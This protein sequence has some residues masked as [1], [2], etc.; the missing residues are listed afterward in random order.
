MIRNRGILFFSLAL[1]ALAFADCSRPE[2]GNGIG[3][4]IRPPSSFQG[5]DSLSVLIFTGPSAWEAEVDSLAELLSAHQLSYRE[6]SSDELN[7]MSLQELSSFNLLIVPGG[8]APTM[9]GSLTAAT[10]QRLRD[11]VQLRGLNYLGFCAGAWLAVAPAPSQPGADVV[12]G[13]GIVPGPIQQ[14]TPMY[15]QRKQFSINRARF[16]DGSRRDLLW[17]GG[18][19]T[20]NLQG[21]VVVEYEDGHPAVSQI[22]S[23]AG[24]VIISGLHPTANAFIEYALGLN[25][26]QL[27]DPEL[28]W[29]LI[30]SAITRTPLPS[31]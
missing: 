15:F 10:H 23:G 20:P 4:G 3:S 31:F 22:H 27:M 17:Y 7:S 18:P 28:T 11:A 13:V 12:Y 19:I 29:Q 6:I 25:D 16:P 14:Q 30:D 24:F 26:P 21:G 9:T 5:K 1:L 8:D 2:S